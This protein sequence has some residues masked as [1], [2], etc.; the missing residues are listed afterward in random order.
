MIVKE[1]AMDNFTLPTVADN[2]TTNALLNND[3]K[4][5]ADVLKLTDDEL[6][7]LKGFGNKAYQE[8][9]EKL[10]EL[11]FNFGADGE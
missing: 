3:I 9:R 4:T 2:P 6:R 10:D 11:G 1:V 8:V 7:S 5:I